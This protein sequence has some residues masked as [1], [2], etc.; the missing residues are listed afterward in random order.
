MWCRYDIGTRFM[1]DSFRRCPCRG[2]IDGEGYDISQ[3][4]PNI[5][6]YYHEVT[7]AAPC[8]FNSSTPAF[9]LQQGRLCETGLDPEEMPQEL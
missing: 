6:A 1:I 8:P 3:I 2:M 7:L 9:V 4:K 5:A